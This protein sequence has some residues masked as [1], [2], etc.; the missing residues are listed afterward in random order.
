VYPLLQASRATATS[1]GLFLR[2]IEWKAV[3]EQ[4]DI[5]IAKATILYE[6]SHGMYD[7]ALKLHDAHNERF[8]YD[9]HVLRSR[10]VKGGLN[11]ALWLQQ[12]IIAE[13]QKPV[14]EQVEWIL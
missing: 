4:S 11:K 13:L 14:K 12:L 3:R 5:R 8:G 6:G 10:I 1:Q 2:P 9:M 7:L